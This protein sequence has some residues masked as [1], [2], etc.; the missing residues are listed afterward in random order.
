MVIK[1]SKPIKKDG[2]WRILRHD[3]EVVGAYMTKELCEQ[4]IATHAWLL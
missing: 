4:A 3:G 1:Q 2:A